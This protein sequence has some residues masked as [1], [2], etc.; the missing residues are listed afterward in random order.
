[1]SP[2]DGVCHAKRF[3][4]AAPSDA[5]VDNDGVIN[6]LTLQNLESW[7]ISNIRNVFHCRL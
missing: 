2:L 6:L 3:P 5:T 7:V 1:V 4:Q